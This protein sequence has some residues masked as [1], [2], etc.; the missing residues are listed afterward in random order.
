MPGSIQRRGDSL[1]LTISNGKGLWGK[2]ERFTK[3]VPIEGKTEKQQEDY[4]EAQLALFY[5]EVKN[6][7]ISRGLNT[8][9]KT[10]SD[11]WKTKYAE[12]ELG[13]KTKHRY[14]EML[15]MRINPALGH[16]TLG[17]FI[18]KPDILL[19][20]YNNLRESG[21]RLD[22]KFKIKPD[23]E[24]LLEKENLSSKE[25]IIK[26]GINPRT[27]KN[28]ISFNNTTKAV[29]ERIS[30][31]L[32]IKIEEIFDLIQ[33][34]QGLDEQT[35]LHH[36]SLISSMFGKAVK[37]N[38]IK[39]NPAM[40]IDRPGVKKKEA[41]SYNIHHA[42][43][44]IKALDDAP[45]KFKVIIVLTIFTGVRE[46]E[47]MGLEW[48]DI[49]FENYIV[50]LRRASQ[51]IPGEGTFTKNEL[52]TEESKREFYLPKFVMNLLKSYKNWQNIYKMQVKN[53]WIESNR[54][55]TQNNGLPMH[56]YTPSKWLPKF[57]KS[58]NIKIMNN[59]DI[60]EKN[61]EKYL[62]PDLNFH[63][64]RHTNLTILLRAGLDIATVSK[65]AGHSRKSTTLDTYSH[66]ANYIDKR[67]AAA[68]ESI[69]VEQPQRTTKRFR[70]KHI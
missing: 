23:F 44:L 14:Y 35:I 21:I 69:L 11:S 62:L 46:E 54:L 56:P 31:A 13:K 39:E 41:R 17:D 68:L 28:I 52:K 42:K 1:L 65:W 60:S 38:L 3:T 27:L 18:L 63:G 51:Y 19:D 29:A 47:L 32:N 66:A 61:K 15:D 53:K 70:L 58:Q 40:R 4:G 57:I 2:R 36:H 33:S 43:M 22:F 8:T 16:I 12:I 34:E 59:E 10:L 7:N 49:D 24:K 67:P 50:T 30:K 6:N 20:F 64:L 48:T 25:L 26:S 9:F 45:F 5:A 55:F 37:W